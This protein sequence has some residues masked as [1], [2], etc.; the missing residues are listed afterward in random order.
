M[1]G[2]GL[3]EAARRPEA[4]VREGDVDATEPLERLGDERFLIGP[5]RDVAA[6]GESVLGAAELLRETL[7][8]VERTGGEDDA[9]ADLGS[10]AGGRG[11][12]SARGAG[13]E[14]D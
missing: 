14:E 3:E 6:D 1:L 4:R 8:P 9:V 12:D 2:R 11:A 7:E 5:L 13:D 10:V